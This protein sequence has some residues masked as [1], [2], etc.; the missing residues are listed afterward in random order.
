M[1]EIDDL[2]QV[3]QIVVKAASKTLS[4]PLS[5][6]DKDGYIVG[7]TDKD[8]IGTFHPVS[9]EVIENGKYIIYN[10][11]DVFGLKNVFP[12]VAVPLIFHNERIG[13]LGLIG[14][15]DEVKSYAELAKHYVELMW[16]ETFYK[17]L[18]GLKKE[19]DD[20]YLQY[21]LLNDRQDE[22]RIMQYCEAL[23]IR[24][25]VNYFCFII[26]LGDY[27]INNLDE[28]NTSLTVNNIK[29]NIIRDISN[30]YPNYG[31][32]K[33]IFLNASKLAV[34]KSA[35]KE[36]DYLNFMNSF[37]ENS[38]NLIDKLNAHGLT[39]VKVSIGK[40][41]SDIQYIQS[42]YQEA[43]N[44]LNLSEK[45]L[46]KHSIFSYYDWDILAEILPYKINNN[47]RNK[48]DFRL[49][50]LIKNRNFDDLQ[51]SFLTYCEENMNISEAAKKLYIHRNTLIYRLKR[52]E[53]LTNIDTNQFKQC[54]VLYNLLII[55]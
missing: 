52:L 35:P 45:I 14:N 4:F 41:S 1:I 19:I 25:D 2:V 31:T 32:T 3:A 50:S 22:A 28:N 16:Q 38:F 11:E 33:T 44:L 23:K 24:P 39:D 42:S 10:E 55:R 7:A 18:A 21:L 9:K 20:T 27:F 12:G 43:N 46:S 49:A 17:E 15:P 5:L 6:S 54:M 51:I 40:L 53:E 34:L 47:F 30:C 8:R 36:E 48:A 13:V 26:D 37:S 29:D